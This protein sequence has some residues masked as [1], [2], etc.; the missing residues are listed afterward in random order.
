MQISEKCLHDTL[1][2]SQTHTKAQI[3]FLMSLIFAL[4][5]GG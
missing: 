3:K 1:T 2:I 4:V 5:N